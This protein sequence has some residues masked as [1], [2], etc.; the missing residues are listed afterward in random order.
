[1]H[2]TSEEWKTERFEV[3]DVTDFGDDM[4]KIFEG[5]CPTYVM[6]PERFRVCRESGKVKFIIITS[7]EKGKAVAG[8]L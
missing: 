3:I 7:D 1:M 8:L 5:W 4:I 2:V 6:S